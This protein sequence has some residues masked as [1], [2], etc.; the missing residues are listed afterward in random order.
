MTKRISSFVT[1]MVIF[2][3]ALVMH[4]STIHIALADVAHAQVIPEI[5]GEVETIWNNGTNTPSFL[6]GQMPLPA[7]VQSAQVDAPSAALGFLTQYQ[8]LFGIADVQH[9]L[10]VTQNQIDELGLDHIT[11][12]QVYQGVEVHNALLKV[13]LDRSKGEVVAVSSSFLPG[14]TLPDVQPR[15]SAEQ[16]LQSAKILLP[17]GSLRQQP[18]LKIYAGSGSARAANQAH[19][20]WLVELHDDAIPAR[21]VYV[22]D[23]VNGQLIDRIEMILDVE[24]ANMHPLAPAQAAPDTPNQPD[25]VGGEEAQPGAY[26]WMA[27]LVR[28]DTADAFTGLFCGGT[29]IYPRWVL[30]ASHCVVDKETGAIVDPANVIVVLGRHNLKSSDGEKIGVT[31]VISHTNYNT[32]THDFDIALLHLDKAST[33][34]PL[35]MIANF[36]NASLFMPDQLTTVL[37]W[38]QTKNA[39]PNSASA[40]LRQTRLPIVSNDICNQS[41]AYNGNITNKMLCAGY[42]QGG[43]D[44]C[45]GDSGGPLLVRNQ[46]NLWIQAGIVSFGDGC[47]QP[48]KYG[49]YTRVSEFHDWV[50]SNLTSACNNVSEIPTSEC[51]ALAILYHSTDG[52]DWIQVRSGDTWLATNTPCT[53]KGVTCTDAGITPRHVTKLELNSDLLRGAIPPELSNLTKLESLDLSGNELRGVIP[54]QVGNLTNLTYL[55]LHSNQLS[56]RMP[57]ELGQLLNLK[58]FLISSNQLSGVLHDALGKLVNLETG[59]F[60]L[61]QFTGAIPP[62]FGKLAKVKK[63]MLDYNQLTGSIPKEL[64]QLVAV[65]QLDL[66]H[67]QLS[68]YIPSELGGLANV[69]TLNLSQNNLSNKI[70][71]ELGKLTS[72]E[73]LVLEHNQLSGGLPATFGD[74]SRL[75]NFFVGSNLLS[76]PLPAELTKLHLGFFAFDQTNLCIPDD[77]A[78]QT[79]L[80]SIATVQSTNLDC[81]AIKN[82]QHLATYNTDHTKNLP[83]TLTRVDDDPAVGD[84]DVDHAHLFAGNVHTYYLGVHGRDSYDNQGTMI[85][86]TAHYGTNYHNAFWDGEQMVYGDGF[87][88]LDVV[89]HELTH[90]VTEH[91][92]QLDYRWQSGALNES[93]SDIFGAMVDRD[94]WLMGEDL[95]SNILGGRGAIRDLADPARLGQPAHTKDW[96]KTCS[97]NEG[98]HT[99]SGIFN[100]AFYNIATAIG[101]EKAEKIFYRSLTAYLQANASFEDARAAVLQATKDLYGANSE[102]T[103][104][105]NGF[106]AVGLDGKWGPPENSCTCAASTVLAQEAAT[107]AAVSMFEVIGTLYRVRDELLDDT[108][109]GQHYRELYYKHTAQITLLLLINPELRAQGTQLLRTFTPGLRSLT[110]G[111]GDTA[112]INAEMTNTVFAYVN[113]LQTLAHQRGN[114]ELAQD[115]EN[116]KARIDW[117]KLSGMSFVEAWRYLNTLDQVHPVFLPFVMR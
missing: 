90:A 73:I 106:K 12:Q 88:V 15:I 75:Y 64:G 28:A 97:D 4:G 104:V 6:R 62:A 71:V 81:T 54:S 60:S 61:N 84:Q 76:G 7:S 39:D 31:K 41:D 50:V 56:G 55:D 21:N 69:R 117:Q 37:G 74:L 29:L 17:T 92:A 26:P 2:L 14:L 85:I 78:V 80:S 111:N 58:T 79:W 100:K 45:Q 93:I 101:K 23:A 8:G 11:L 112:I 30:T 46:N 40:V 66:S 113:N 13:H 77:P 109:I 83:G 102:Y 87:P 34:M 63:L 44:S 107:P 98:V 51:Q 33:Q 103:S 59:E 53:W 16:A 9:E 42:V 96:V 19:L 57:P 43:K 25:I 108:A 95:S 65:Q 99:N 89:A 36:N 10:Y 24:Q 105:S 94:D 91:T 22:L 115:I 32:S 49:V 27:A 18:T 3:L 70:P 116:E 47:A 5:L 86:S 72:L 20:A 48:N 110:D 82:P 1:L 68:G 67:N 35:P 38:G 114:D 52:P